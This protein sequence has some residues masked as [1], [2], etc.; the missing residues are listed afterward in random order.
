MAR[1]RCLK[2][3]QHAIDYPLLSFHKSCGV[4]NMG[5]KIRSANLRPERPEKRIQIPHSASGMLCRAP[6]QCSRESP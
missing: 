4:S 3:Q 2:S 1:K 6:V 5:L